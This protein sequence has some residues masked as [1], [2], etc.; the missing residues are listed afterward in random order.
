MVGHQIKVNYVLTIFAKFQTDLKLY[1]GAGAILVFPLFDFIYT[2]FFP[3]SK[4]CHRSV[5]AFLIIF[6][7][8]FLNTK[9]FSTHV[10]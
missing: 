8:K 3:I 9:N 2:Q 1:M 10:S 5:L 4:K 6:P 7:S